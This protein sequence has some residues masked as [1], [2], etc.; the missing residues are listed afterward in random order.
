M[1]RM[2]LFFMRIKNVHNNSI[3]NITLFENIFIDLP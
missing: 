3:A 2:T 1:D